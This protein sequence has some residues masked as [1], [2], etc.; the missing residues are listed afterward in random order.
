MD[1]NLSEEFKAR[2]IKYLDG[3]EEAGRRGGDFVAE[4]A[5]ETMRQ[6][7]TWHI[8]ENAAWALA[9]L[10]AAAVAM[11]T[12]KHVWK[13]AEGF[14]CSEDRTATKIISSV[15][16][17]VLVC[18]FTFKAFAFAM[19]SAKAAVAPNVYLIETAVKLSKKVGY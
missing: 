2:L 19:D 12:C 7:V 3:I 16:C 8:I 14:R 10:F 18:I 6:F 1:V 4:Q 9:M 5:P 11:Y 17:G 15:V 13:F